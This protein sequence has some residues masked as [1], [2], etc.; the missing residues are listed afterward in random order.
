MPDRCTKERNDVQKLITDAG[1]TFGYS[2]DGKTETRLELESSQTPVPLKI[3]VSELMAEL[4][5]DSPSWYNIGSSV[6]H[7]LHWGLRDINH[8]RPDQ[9]LALTPASSTSAPPPSPPSPPPASS[10]TTA[11]GSSATTRPPGS[12]TQ[13]P[14]AKK[15]TPSCAAPRRQPGLTYPPRHSIAGR[16]ARNELRT[17][18]GGFTRA[19]QEAS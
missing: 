11:P 5:P 2:R 3:N 8:S 19:G 12:S 13:R 18:Y 1:L 9:P 7:S 14:A 6:T 10:S 16:T 15:S 4:L 17:P